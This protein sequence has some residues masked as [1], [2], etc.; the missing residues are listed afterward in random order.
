MIQGRFTHIGRPILDGYVIIPEL[1]P[2]PTGTI[3]F[4]FDTGADTMCIHPFDASRLRIPID[5][6]HPTREARGI[7][8]TTPY[9]T[10][11]AAIGFHRTRRPWQ[12]PKLLVFNVELSV[13]LPNENNWNLPSLLGRDIID[14]FDFRYNRL[15]ER[16]NCRPHSTDYVVDL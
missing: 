3:P 7:G 16:L 15:R 14:R 10:F 11:P 8:G 1:E 4:R 9:A 12:K 5:N 6:L 13:A 2:N